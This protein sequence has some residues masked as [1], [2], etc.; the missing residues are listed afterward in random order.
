[1]NEKIFKSFENG[2]KC[3]KLVKEYLQVNSHRTLKFEQSCS[4]EVDKIL[5]LNRSWNCAKNFLESPK[6]NWERRDPKNPR[7]S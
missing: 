5:G 7:Y 6:V 3:K 1:M 2:V 4:A